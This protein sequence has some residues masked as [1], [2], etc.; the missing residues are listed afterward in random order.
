MSTEAEIKFGDRIVIKGLVA[1]V[2]PWKRTHPVGVFR[3]V[4]EMELSQKYH[5]LMM[6]HNFICVLFDG[7]SCTETIRVE[8]GELT[9]L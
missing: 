4:D 7:N 1:T 2:V 5:E 6:R 9:K 8:F 3:S